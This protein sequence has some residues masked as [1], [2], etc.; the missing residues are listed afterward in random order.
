MVA[1]PRRADMPLLPLPFRPLTRSGRILLCIA[2]SVFAAL[3]R[4]YRKEYAGGRKAA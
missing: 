4:V 1:T 3:L 2:A